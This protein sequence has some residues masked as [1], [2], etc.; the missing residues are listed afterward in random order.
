MTLDHAA[1]VV[2]F[3]G[4]DPDAHT[5]EGIS[6][7]DDPQFGQRLLCEG[8]SWFSLGALPSSNMLFPLRFRQRTLL[9]NLAR[10][11]DTLL[12]MT[13]PARNPQLK[14]ALD[15]TRWNALFISGG[16]NDLIDRIG[17]I[18]CAPSTGAGQNFLD[19]IDRVELARLRVAIHGHHRRLVATRDGS[20]K[21]AGIPIVT[22]VYDYPTPRMAP[23]KFVGIGFKGPWLYP[24]LVQWKVPESFWISIVDYIFESVASA[25]VEL[26]SMLENFHV[27]ATTRGVL[28]R[29]RLGTTGDDAD[30]LNEIH[31]NPGGFAKLAGVVSPELDALL[32]GP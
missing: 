10:P 21:N 31:P 23:A 30:W 12:N 20:R 16:G 32:F 9:V 14:Q 29:A 19:Y 1:K 3:K 25:L 13:D 28:A 18:V 4:Y 2:S 6:G 27:I 24:A 7:P 11:G 5:A 17:H 15:E 22:H 8:D 26:S